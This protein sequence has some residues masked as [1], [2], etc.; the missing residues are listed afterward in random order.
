MIL[1]IFSHWNVHLQR[2]FLLK[3]LLFRG[4]PIQT[5]MNPATIFHAMAATKTPMGCPTA[6]GEDS[7]SISALRASRS[8][9]ERW[10]NQWIGFHG[11]ILTGNHGFYHQIWRAE[12]SKFSH[13][14]ILWLNALK[15]GRGCCHCWQMGIANFVLGTNQWSAVL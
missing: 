6:M 13:H 12:T 4:F 1:K 8:S 9:S 5:S 14:P 15:K 2:I 10:L 11:K 3:P 7:R